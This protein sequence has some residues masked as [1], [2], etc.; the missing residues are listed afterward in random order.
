VTPST[1][2][3][4]GQLANEYHLLDCPIANIGSSLGLK[5]RWLFSVGL[6]KL[7]CIEA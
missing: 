5:A 3:A 7:D 4:I 1:A 2:L 6:E